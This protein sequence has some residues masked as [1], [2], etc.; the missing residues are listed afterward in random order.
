ML[1]SREDFA[2]LWLYLKGHGSPIEDTAP[3]LSRN[4][5]KASGQ[6]E[7]L[8]RTMICLDVFAER[9]LISITRN[10]DH[11]QIHL[12]P[13]QTKVDLEQSRIM[14]TLRRIMEG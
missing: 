2:T 6:R 12:N 3:R 7:T 10:T 14:C 1:P 4:L 9:G 8:M 11:L 5:A 13:V